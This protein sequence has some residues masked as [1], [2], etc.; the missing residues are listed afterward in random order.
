[1]KWLAT[2][3]VALA[4]LFAVVSEWRHLQTWRLRERA[5]QSYYQGDFK[6]TLA[7]YDAVIDRRSGEPRS[8]T[9]PADTL[10]Q[11]LSG[12]GQDLPQQEFDR[13]AALAVGYYLHALDAS[14]PNAWAYARL[15]TLANSMGKRLARD[16]QIDLAIL[17][18]TPDALTPQDRFCEA[19]WVKAVQI[20][21]RNFY[22]RD[23]LGDFYLRRGFRERALGHF[24]YAVRLHPVLEKHYYLS[25]FAEASPEVLRAVELGVQDALAAADTDVSPYNIHRFLA[26]LYLKL[27]RLEDAE[28]S[29]LAA[30]EHSPKPHAVD[31]QIGQLRAR[32]GDDV[33][34]LEAFRRSA[35]RQPDYPKAWLHLALTWSR[36][37]RHEEAVG[38]AYKARGLDPGNFAISTALARVLEAA[39][40]LEEAA[41]ILEHLIRSDGDKRQPYTSLIAIYE[42]MGQISKAT[43]T[44]RQLVNRFP[45]EEIFQEQL[46]RLEESRSSR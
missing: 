12:A 37:S 9:D 46:E 24:R 39:G 42:N 29:L 26:E 11:Y 3:F 32:Q 35:E 34:A 5:E 14:P 17:S 8:Y 38:A 21:P 23:Y 1:M 40:K 28:A 44:A 22:Y 2:G 7:R 33:G 6:K 36:M 41:E 30:A 16:G 13:L 19:A 25:D 10:S 4:A 27:G 15:A 43:R 18:G 45:D 31:L 20:E